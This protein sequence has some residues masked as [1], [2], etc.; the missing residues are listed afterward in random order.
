MLKNNKHN[1][2]IAQY[3]TNGHNASEAHKTAYPKVKSGW[4]KHG[5][6]LMARDD[7]KAEIRRKQALLEVKLEHNREIAIK[8]LLHNIELYDKIIQQGTDNDKLGLAYVQAIKGRKESIQE[9]NAISNLHKATIVNERTPDQ[10]QGEEAE[11]LEELNRAYK[12]K[13]SKSSA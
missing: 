2:F 10:P 5:S 9:L 3:L 7:I 8:M 13:L 11:L 4:N 6:R 1:E 12:L